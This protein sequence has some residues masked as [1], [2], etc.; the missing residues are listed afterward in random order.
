VI[1][2]E[3]TVTVRLVQAGELDS[4]AGGEDLEPLFDYKR[5]QPRMTFSFDGT[6]R[7]ALRGLEFPMGE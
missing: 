1:T 6:H 7:V 5:V 4:A 2:S 3:R